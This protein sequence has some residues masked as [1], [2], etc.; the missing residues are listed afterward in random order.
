MNGV[1]IGELVEDFLPHTE[2][3]NKITSVEIVP[4]AIVEAIIAECI[5]C[6]IEAD[7]EG[8]KNEGKRKAF[9][10]IQTFAELQLINFE[11]G[12]DDHE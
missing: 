12:G 7:E 8:E 1:T 6:R 11:N 3:G 9:S 5:S 4:R 10:H 2:K